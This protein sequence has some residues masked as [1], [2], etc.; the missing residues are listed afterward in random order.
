MRHL[1]FKALILAPVL[2]S[3]ST[4]Q[5]P[6]RTIPSPL[7][8]HPGNVFLAGEEVVLSVPH[9][10]AGPWRLLDYEGK[11]IADPK[12]SEGRFLLGRL[13][14]GYYELRRDKEST[15]LAVLAPLKAPTSLRS[16]IALDVAMAWFY[17]K[18]KMEAVSSLCALAGVNRVRDRLLWGEIETAKGK[19]TPT[20]RYDDSAFAQ[21]R[22]GLEVLQVMHRSPEWAAK[23]PSRF[24]PD[25]RDAYD[26][27]QEVARRWRNEVTAFEPWNEAD[28]SAFGGH[29]GSEM[30]SFQKAC[31]LG[32][33]AGNPS[34]TACLN[35]F[36][37]HNRAQLEDLRDNEAWPYFDTFNLHHYAPFDEYPQL[38]ADFRAV[39]AG[40]PLWVSE[41]ALPV[42][43]AG[44]P[45]LQ[46]PTE[47]DSRILAERVLKT[48]VCSLHEG[49]A[50]TFY[51]LLPHY[52][53]GQTQFGILR[54]D[55]TPRPGYV[56]LAAAGRLLANARPLGRLKPAAAAARAFLFS[57]NPD[58]QPAT[59]LVAWSS[60]GEYELPLPLSPG[61]LFDHL[62][63]NLK[64]SAD[65]RLNS[66]PLIALFPNDAAKRFTLE[67]PP[68]TPP[69]LPGA[70]S[71]VVLQALWPEDCVVLSRSACR[72]FSDKETRI[73]VFAYNFGD[74]PVS[75][76]LTV[77]MPPGWQTGPLPELNDLAPHSRVELT[78]TLDC[79]PSTTSHL[80]ETIQVVGDFG[81]AG[82]PVLSFR[83][84]PDPPLLV[85]QR[86]PPVPGANEPSR[87]QPSVSG[88][89][90]A[91]VSEQGGGLVIDA[92]PKGADKWVYPKLPLAVESRPPAGAAGLC[93][94][95]QLLEGE[96][97]FRAIFDEENGSSYV[98]DFTT[99]PKH[100]ETTEALALF[101]TAALGAGW[102]KPDSNGKLDPMEIVS[103]KIGCNPRTDRI[104]FTIRNVRWVK[105]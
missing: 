32:L 58:G 64:I 20:T 59:V 43:W 46:E 101:E 63:R 68:A 25:L 30:A 57:A 6:S 3:S 92:A 50:A 86:G 7:A 88:D 81:P 33:K 51:F 60:A 94:T 31:W 37:L 66:G 42:K 18:D 54:K 97:Q 36:A 78:L 98:A 79:R 13:P 40:R 34:V 2:A 75:G 19:F 80:T 21:S 8:G 87:W 44:D 1:L 16:P 38:Y 52:V 71:P 95:L 73:P 23:V 55:L 100:G 105:P 39:S 11:A 85:R 24:P 41:C 5:Q 89:G 45:V 35:V 103:L 93:C 4:A 14:V 15:S 47:A 67:P 102:S 72:V 26:F 9:S 77:T 82:R 104:R 91:T 76:R 49:S 10:R 48:F 83:V 28:I 96:A 90:F 29:T 61:G 84:M 17:P 53:E 99:R 62:G 69:R 74:T 70:P 56:A 27:Y 65:L 22:A 12:P